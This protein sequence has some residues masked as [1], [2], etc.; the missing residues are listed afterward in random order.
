M[1]LP[2]VKRWGGLLLGAAIVLGALFLGLLV[3]T[4][5]PEFQNQD[6]VV[7]S[8]PSIEFRTNAGVAVP[9]AV[10]C[11]SNAGPG[12][13]DFRLCWF[14]CRARQQKTL[15]ATNRFA[16]MISPLGAGNATNL[17]MEVAAANLPA[18]DYCCCAEVIWVERESSSHRWHRAVDGLLNT[19]DLTKNPR[20]YSRELL[21][22][23]A[24]ASN[25]NP[26]EYFRVMYGK[27]RS[28]WLALARKWPWISNKP[29][30]NGIYQT[31]AYGGQ[32]PEEGTKVQ[33]E[34][35]FRDFCRASNNSR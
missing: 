3:A 15:L 30:S 34:M 22:G 29:V 19:F 35:A 27:T 33:A 28:Q 8:I 20:W 9:K 24:I 12:A 14:E 31:G 1:K 4:R 11:V 5:R 18:G 16:A 6:W 21:Q 23:N 25:T 10:V 26:A 32:D 7:L 13:V 17:T 2:N